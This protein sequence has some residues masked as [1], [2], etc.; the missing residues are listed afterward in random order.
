MAFEALECVGII[1]CDL[2]QDN[3][4]LV[5]HKEKPYKLKLIDFGVACRLED[6]ELGD[7]IQNVTFR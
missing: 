4:M 2:K 5:D 1:H 7:V 6:L 3:I